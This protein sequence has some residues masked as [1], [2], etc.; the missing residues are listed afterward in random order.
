[1]NKEQILNHE[2]WKYIS[3]LSAVAR[4]SALFGNS[5]KQIEDFYRVKIESRLFTEMNKIPDDV[6]TL[7]VTDPIR[8]MAHIA[9][10]IPQ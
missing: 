7:S 6:V 5:K 9:V 4:H 1:M 8:N 2:G 10:L 3:S